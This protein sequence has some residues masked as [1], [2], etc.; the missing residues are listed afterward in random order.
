MKSKKESA[1]INTWLHSLSTML[2]VTLI[3]DEEGMCSLQ[4]GEEQMIIQALTDSPFLIIYEKLLILP[5]DDPD[6][7]L[8]LMIRALEMNAFQNI[9][10]GGTIAAAPGCEFLIYIRSISISESTSIDQC[11]QLFDSIL[12]TTPKLREHI[13]GFSES[14]N[15]ATKLT[16]HEKSNEK[17]A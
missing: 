7:K 6:L 10:Q 14:S 4:V 5:K 17:N 11:N 13:F 16:E 12:E 1:I 3:L 9:T 8:A 15:L 2:K